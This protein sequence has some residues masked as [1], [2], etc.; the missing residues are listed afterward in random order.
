MVVLLIDTRL[1]MAVLLRVNNMRFITFLIVTLFSLP[2]FAGGFTAPWRGV[3]G[4]CNHELG[5]P[6]TILEYCAQRDGAEDLEDR[7]GSNLVVQSEDF[8]TT[9][10]AARVTVSTDQVKNPINGSLDA[11]VIS[12]DG[13]AA[14]SH[15][16]YQGVDLVDGDSYSVS[17]YIRA[18]NRQWIFAYITTENTGLYCNAATGV[19]GNTNGTLIGSGVEQID[20]LWVRCW[21]SFKATATATRTLQ[22]FVAEANGDI[23]FDG[24]SQTSL[25]LWGAQVRQCSSASEC[26][27][28]GKYLKTE[29][30]NKPVLDLADTNDPTNEAVGPV[31][32][33]GNRQTVQTFD[34]TNYF[35]HAHDDAMNVND[36]DHTYTFLARLS[37]TATD[38]NIVFSHGGFRLS[39][40]YFYESLATDTW[41]ANYQKAA[42]SISVVVTPGYALN[43]GHWHVGQIIRRGNIAVFCLD[44]VCGLPVNV[45]TYGIDGDQSIYIGRNA[46]GNHR[47][48][49]IAYL[50]ID[51]KAQSPWKL[52]YDL[53]YL[54]GVASSLGNP[55]AVNVIVDGDMEAAEDVIVDG[56]MEAVGVAAWTVA[57]ATVTKETNS[58]KV[59]FGM[60][61]PVYWFNAYDGQCLAMAANGV[62]YGTASQ[63]ILTIGRTYHATGVAYAVTDAGLHVPDIVDGVNVLWT[64]AWSST[65][66]PFDVEFVATTTTLDF[67]ASAFIPTIGAVLFDD[68]IV[69][70]KTAETIAWTPI[71][72]AILSKVTVGHHQGKRA[73]RNAFD[74]TSNPVARQNAMTEGYTYRVTGFA[75]GDG[76]I[77]IPELRF[78]A[79]QTVWT[80]TNSTDWQA[81]DVT[82]VCM[83]PNFQL[84][85]LANNAAWTEWDDIVLRE[86]SRTI[87]TFT[88]S[89]VGT[90][91]TPQGLM[92]IAAGNPRVADGFLIEAQAT[93][94]EDY[95][96]NFAG[97][98]S[99][100]RATVPSCTELDP[101]GGALAC[102]I[103]EDATA[104]ST[105]YIN[106]SF[107][108]VSGTAY[109]C[110]V[111]VKSENRNWVRI[112]L[113][114]GGGSIFNESRFFN[115]L[116]GVVGGWVGADP[117]SYGMEP[118]GNG[119]YR[120]WVSEEADDD[121]TGYCFIYI[122]EADVDNTFDGLDQDSLIVYGAQLEVGLFPTSYISTNGSQVTRTAD[123]YNIDPHPEVGERLLPQSFDESGVLTIQF[124][125]KCQWTDSSDMGILRRLM[126]VSGDTGTASATRNR[127]GIYVQSWGA[128]YSVLYGDDGVSYFAITLSNDV[129]LNTWTRIKTK[130]DFSDLS[131]LDVWIAQPPEAELVAKGVSFTA[132]SG[133]ADFDSTDTRIRVGQ[134]NTGGN[135]GTANCQFKNIRIEPRAF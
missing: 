44:G 110:S 35:S 48:G 6:R 42:A 124:D 96:E 106:N 70:D 127:I 18:S 14:N 56:D 34:G 113:G 132:T 77:G 101:K 16:V 135:S 123:S 13:T 63:T 43:D 10:T 112:A 131:S 90:L 67:R 64:G 24:L 19:A 30:N 66:Q 117:D 2:V 1:Q 103:H 78:G 21:F 87:G 62:Q 40:M 50:R 75:R 119:F 94:I 31:L 107:T 118:V 58:I 91:E 45:S 4:T 98:W 97:A 32:D 82:A 120:V 65:W 105:H 121:G 15:I 28:P 86:Y 122:G 128:I 81:F 114:G 59:G 69:M 111:H 92:D 47:E 11:D 17:M 104:A 39:G 25:Y 83:N 116:S 133:T 41:V 99:K 54:R 129:S 126:G 37:T 8:G 95:S 51:A 85:T 130:F 102:I 55:G 115:V 61:A 57:G 93:N 23:T 33:N 20:P 49:S 84:Y 12:E 80:G 29:A 53:A 60:F 73:L 3:G 68:V 89:T 109:T 79:L 5:G 27:G 88:R 9:W 22:T 100:L 134:S 71:N 125:L 72:D 46:D 7:S 38:S 26:N 108:A 52:A 76:G 74:G 36:S